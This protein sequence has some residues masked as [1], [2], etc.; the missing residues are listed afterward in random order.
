MA[1]YSMIPKSFVSMEGRG[2]V[3][4][5]TNTDV[6]IGAGDWP[7]CAYIYIGIDLARHYSGTR[8]FSLAVRI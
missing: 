2:R 6:V 3:F 5:N 4:M 8:T 7:E 1:L